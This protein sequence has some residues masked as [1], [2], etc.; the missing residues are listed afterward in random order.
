ME[1]VPDSHDIANKAFGLLEPLLP[2]RKG[3]WGG[4]AKNNRQFINRGLLGIQGRATVARF[5]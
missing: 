2:R 5:A 1:R 3:V 4:I